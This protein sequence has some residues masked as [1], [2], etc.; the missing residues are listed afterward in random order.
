MS[1]QLIER[2]PF[3][4]YP[5]HVFRIND[6][7]AFIA[8]QLDKV[9][10][11]RNAAES[12]QDIPLAKK[13]ID[14]DIIPPYIIDR[15]AR[16]I[17]RS[18]AENNRV[19]ILYQ[20]GLFILVLRSDKPLAVPFT[21]WMLREVIP[22]G[23]EHVR[24]IAVECTREEFEKMLDLATNHYHFFRPRTDEKTIDEVDN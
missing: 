16:K 13:G 6:Q 5:I 21:R 8:R 12:I 10:G 11:F 24:P 17:I 2:C 9:L 4:D 15:P 7:V 18:F 19:V 14:Y 22:C 23:L 1:N 20:S 3:N